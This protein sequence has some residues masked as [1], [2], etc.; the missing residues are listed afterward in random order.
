MDPEISFGK[1]LQCVK[2]NNLKFTLIDFK[3]TPSVEYYVFQNKGDV[4][5]FHVFQHVEII[6]S[7]YFAIEINFSYK[8]KY[9]LTIN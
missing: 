1:Y 6:C 2:L 3:P 7:Y 9:Q 8:L 4:N 5:Y